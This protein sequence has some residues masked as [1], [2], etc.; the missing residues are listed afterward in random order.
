MLRISRQF[1]MGTAR[2]VYLDPRH[3]WQVALFK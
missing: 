3:Q 2:P 1:G